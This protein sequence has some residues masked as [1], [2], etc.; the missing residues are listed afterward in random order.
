MEVPSCKIITLSTVFMKSSRLEKQKSHNSSTG[1][2][3]H[4][5]RHV[6]DNIRILTACYI[7]RNDNIYS[8]TS[9]GRWL[10]LSMKRVKKILRVR[11][12]NGI[13]QKGIEETIQSYAEEKKLLLGK[14]II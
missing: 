7:G 6:L 5:Y 2:D 9:F 10:I 13:K 14:R 8:K 1:N 4:R 3:V 12:K 11:L